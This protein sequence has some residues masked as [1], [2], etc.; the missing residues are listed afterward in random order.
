[1]A[2]SSSSLFFFVSQNRHTVNHT[3]SHFLL[4]YHPATIT[5]NRNPWN[6]NDALDAWLLRDDSNSMME[7]EHWTSCSHSTN[8]WLFQKE[9]ALPPMMRSNESLPTMILVDASLL[10]QAEPRPIEP[11]WSSHDAL[12]ALLLKGETWTSDNDMNAWL[13]QEETSLS[14]R[15]SNEPMTTQTIAEEWRLQETEPVP[16][17]SPAVRASSDSCRVRKASNHDHY[18]AHEKKRRCYSDR[19]ER[20]RQQ[21][22]SCPPTQRCPPKRP[23]SPPPTFT[24]KYM[25]KLLVGPVCEFDMSEIPVEGAFSDSEFQWA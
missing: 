11:A 17:R 20:V 10:N 1:M 5:M 3:L 19:V 2:Y 12:E 9:A 6:S 4:A 7:N 18:L 24:S 16:M 13:L 25:F 8:P 14:N 23:A 15:M 22:I 21:P